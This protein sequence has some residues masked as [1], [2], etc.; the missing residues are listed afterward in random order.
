M[1]SCRANSSLRVLDRGA[2]RAEQPRPIAFVPKTPAEDAIKGSA[3]I[4]E[5]TSEVLT[6]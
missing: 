4:D 1:P 5:K 6:M 2:R 3:W